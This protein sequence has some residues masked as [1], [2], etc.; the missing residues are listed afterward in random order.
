MIGSLI[1]ENEMKQGFIVVKNAIYFS[2]FK[3][4]D[5]VIKKRK[6]FFRNKIPKEK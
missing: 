6:S 3:N 4:D 2:K 5:T 1:A